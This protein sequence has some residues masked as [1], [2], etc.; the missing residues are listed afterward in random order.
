MREKRKQRHFRKASILM[1]FCQTMYKVMHP[2]AGRSSMEV[3]KWGCV[4]K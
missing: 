2:D 3:D 4:E 1:Q